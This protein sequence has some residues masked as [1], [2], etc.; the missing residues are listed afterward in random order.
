M[1]I[2]GFEHGG[3]VNYGDKNLLGGVWR[4]DMA[5]DVWGRAFRL[6]A[7][8]IGSADCVTAQQ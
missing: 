5:A 2:N 4:N 6:A 7:V 8:S 3:V 1:T